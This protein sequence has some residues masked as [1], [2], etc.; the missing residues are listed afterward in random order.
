MY[1]SKCDVSSML[2]VLIAIVGNSTMYICFVYSTDPADPRIVEYSVGP[3][4]NPTSYEPF[5]MTGF[6]GP[7]PYDVRSMDAPTH[8][9]PLW[10]AFETEMVKLNDVFETVTNGYRYPPDCEDRYCKATDFCGV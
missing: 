4:P 2:Y 8:F 5:Q 6:N 1:I 7:V 10:K 3:I 9:F